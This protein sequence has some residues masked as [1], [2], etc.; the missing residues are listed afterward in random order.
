MRTT[1]RGSWWSWAVAAITGGCLVISAMLIAVRPEVRADEGSGQPNPDEE[2]IGELHPQNSDFAAGKEG[3][4]LISTKHDDQYWT[5]VPTTK[6][7]KPAQTVDRKVTISAYVVDSKNN[8]AAG[9]TVYF[10]VV[11]PDPDDPSPYEPDTNPGDNRDGAIQAGTLSAGSDVTVLKTI[12][13]IEH[14]VAEVELTITDRYAGDNYT[15][16]AS[17]YSNFPADKTLKT[18]LLT[19]WKRLYVEYDKMMRSPNTERCVRRHIDDDIVATGNVVYIPDGA[20][21]NFP[22]DTWVHVFD[23]GS[24]ATQSGE[25]RQVDHV[26]TSGTPAVMYLKNPPLTNQYRYSNYA[27][28]GPVEYVGGQV[29]EEASYFSPDTTLL[30]AAYDPAFVE[31]RIP[32]DARGV[33]PYFEYMSTVDAVVEDF[34]QRWFLH[35]DTRQDDAWTSP[36][37]RGM[38]KTGKVNYIHTIGACRGVGEGDVAG[39]GPWWHNCILV[40]VKD[41]EN[42]YSEP[43]VRAWN[44]QETTVHELGHQFQV[45]AKTPEV[46]C[47]NDA[48]TPPNDG[49]KCIMTPYGSATN[50]RARFCKMHIYD[51][52]LSQP[53]I[54]DIGD[55]R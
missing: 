38:F 25:I 49:E 26:D 22:P 42:R 1:A 5:V 8:P 52:T 24:A 32:E 39:Y 9:V 2:A 17:L 44:N 27:H 6:A 36:P 7:D 10:R 34:S 43:T 54:R 37:S 50:G 40:F 12:A 11:D 45:D 41:I 19:A 15:V 23:C 46:H 4:I 33:V 16:E 28:V 29:N 35:K 13:G 3:R 53:S 30:E 31:F 21:P 51:G 47:S 48:Y 20:G 14:A 55:N 18:A